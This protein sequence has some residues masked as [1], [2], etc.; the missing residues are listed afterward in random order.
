MD[1]YWV[2]IFR[3]V[4]IMKGNKTVKVKE[5]V[6]KRKNAIIGASLLMTGAAIGWYGSRKCLSNLIGPLAECSKGSNY[7]YDESFFGCEEG[8]VKGLSKLGERLIA[9][10]NVTG[11]GSVTEDTKV[12]GLMVFMKKD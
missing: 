10:D 5:F 7:R 6:K 1:P 11:S 9:F 4:T 8:T 2:L 12:T 3:R